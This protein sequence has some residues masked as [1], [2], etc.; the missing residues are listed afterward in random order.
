M[1]RSYNGEAICLWTP[2]VCV[3][4]LTSDNVKAVTVTD[5]GINFMV[6]LIYVRVYSKDL[7][8]IWSTL[9]M[10]THYYTHQVIIFHLLAW[11]ALI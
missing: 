8:I 2:D 4:F 6:E 5:A 9:T 7:I 3:L 1:R 11:V 10:W